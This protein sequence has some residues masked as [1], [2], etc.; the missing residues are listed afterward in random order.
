MENDHPFCHKKAEKPPHIR[1]GQA[2]ES[3]ATAF[4]L[5]RGMQ[6]LEKNWRFKRL[7]IDLVCLDEPCL[8]FVEVKTRRSADFGGPIAAISMKKKHNLIKAAQGWQYSHGAWNRPV[9][10]DVLCLLKHASGFT[11]EY[12]E[13]AFEFSS[14]DS[15]HST[16]QPW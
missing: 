10:F 2:G 12:Y 3:F 4:L 5:A 6:V 15:S 16:W 14:L 11:V 1:L 8:V 7:E 13:N 9:R